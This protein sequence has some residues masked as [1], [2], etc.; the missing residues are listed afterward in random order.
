MRTQ[1]LVHH[2]PGVVVTLVFG[3][4]LLQSFF[5]GLP[6]VAHVVHAPIGA[7]P[8]DHVVDHT[9]WPI[10]HIGKIGGILAAVIDIGGQ[11]YFVGKVVTGAEVEVGGVE[12]HIGY[13][14]AL[15][16]IAYAKTYIVF[17][18]LGTDGNVVGREHSC[19]QK[20]F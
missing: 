17:I 12:V 2:E 18:A 1:P 9:I 5:A 6:V 16:G 19:L 14:S 20:M 4:D 11:F 10:V 13:D 7:G 3:I 8:N 15:V